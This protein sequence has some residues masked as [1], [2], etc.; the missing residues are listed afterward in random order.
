ME[1]VRE[2]GRRRRGCLRPLARYALAGFVGVTLGSSVALV[3]H[4]AR[5]DAP[6]VALPSDPVLA[7]LIEES[8]AARPELAKAEA[9]V[10]A[11]EER[12]PQVGALPD[13]MLQIGI[14]NDGFTSIEIGRME[15]SFVSFMASQT[16][17]WPGKLGLRSDVA[18]LGSAQATTQ[19]ARARLSAEADVRRAYLDLLLARDRL[20]LLARLEVLWRQSAEVTRILYD[21]GKAPQSDLLRAQLELQRNKQRRFALEGEEKSR[22]QTL[23]RLRNHPL[24]EPIET[25]ARIQDLVPPGGLGAHF[26]A[27]RAIA[28]SPELEASR[29]E[30]TRAGKSVGLAEKGYYPDLTVGAGIMY[31]GQLPPMWL[32]TVGGPLPIFAGEKQSRAVAEGRAWEG[33]ARKDVATLEQVVRLRSEERHTA[34]ASLL[35]TIDVYSQGLLVTSEATAESTLNQYKV[36]KVT[37]ASVL[38]A[39]VGLIADHEGYLEAV[40]AAHRLLIAEAEV[41]LVPTAMPGGSLGTSS[42]MPGTG[43]A[44]METG[45]STGAG[46]GTSGGAPSS[47]SGSSM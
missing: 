2:D 31:R 35:G 22:V 39:N 9:V 27:E 12:V 10:H 23:N 29:L 17:P 14:Q 19:V 20:A 21:A 1:H 45:G 47:G 7:R 8:L 11:Q 3:A 42:A 36:G 46:A 32:A 40:A 37:F 43:A 15:T 25:S 44:P 5:A 26:S 4:P 30:T 41:S 6:S 18:R 16:F 13:P 33:A 34:F 38:E 24:D 28:R